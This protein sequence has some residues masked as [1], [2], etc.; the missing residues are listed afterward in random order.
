MYP[1]CTYFNNF[2]PSSQLDLNNSKATVAHEQIQAGWYYADD[3]DDNDQNLLSFDFLCC[4]MHATAVWQAKG[5]DESIFCFVDGYYTLHGILDG[6]S[7]D[8]DDEYMM[9]MWWCV[10]ATNIEQQGTKIWW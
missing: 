6:G 5:K 2:P 10:A 7:D 3:N 1:L 4:L 8:D 9:I